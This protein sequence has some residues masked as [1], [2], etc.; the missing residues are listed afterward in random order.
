[1]LYSTIFHLP[2]ISFPCS[3]ARL[4]RSH[5]WSMTWIASQRA[6][7]SYAL[8]ELYLVG[9][10]ILLLSRGNATARWSLWWSMPMWLS[11]QRFLPNLDHFSGYFS[12]RVSICLLASA[13]NQSSNCIRSDDPAQKRFAYVYVCTRNDCVWVWVHVSCMHRE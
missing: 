8:Q 1:M 10:H 13:T 2:S 12:S 11:W 3:Q 7:L 9:W 4:F 6:I 5:V